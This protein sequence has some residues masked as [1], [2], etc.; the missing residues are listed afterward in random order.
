MFTERVIIIG[1][2]CITVVLI[3]LIG[4][5]CDVIKKKGSKDNECE[6]DDRL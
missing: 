1:I 6:N 5:V 2:V 4:S 3:C